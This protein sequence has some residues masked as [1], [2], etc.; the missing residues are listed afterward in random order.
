MTRLRNITI[1]IA[2][3]AS[4]LLLSSCV[5]TDINQP[6]TRTVPQDG[7]WGIYE[8][9]ISTGNV[10]LI[11]GTSDEIFNSTLELNNEGNTLIFAMEIDG[12]FDTDTEICSLGIDG[13][14]LKRL[15]NNQFFDLYPALSPDSSKIAFL[16]W[17]ETDL[18]IYVMDA[19]GNNSRKL[20][21]SG[22]H[23]ADIDWVKDRIVFTSQFSIWQMYDDGSQPEIITD[24]PDRGEWGEANLPIGDYDPRLSPDGTKIVFERLL[25]VS[26]PHG[27]Y[28]IFV[29]NS[30]GSN[31]I[32]LTNTEYSQGLASWS[33]SGEE[34]VYIVAAIDDIGKYDIYL[35]NADG[36]NN[37]N[38][39]PAYFPDSFICHSPI[40]SADDSKILFIGQWWE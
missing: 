7:Q 14:N 5:E 34:I 3:L 19:D 24:L 9:D 22:Y 25:D 26:K 33:H 17:R 31:E 32:R 30:D 20:Y 6:D 2:F 10:S 15:T 28:D 38:I 40:F 11:Y 39:T 27:G 16:S 13:Q 4:F 29:V 21:D 1:T 23:D 8:L 18:D 36:S 12:E 35:M 37:R